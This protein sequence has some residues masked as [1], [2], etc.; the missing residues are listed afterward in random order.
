LERIETITLENASLQRRV[1]NVNED[2]KIIKLHREELKNKMHIFL[3]ENEILHK[4]VN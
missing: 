1:K 4:S 2:L 3:K